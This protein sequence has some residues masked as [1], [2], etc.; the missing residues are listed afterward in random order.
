MRVSIST[1]RRVTGCVLGVV[2]LGLLAS[3]GTSPTVEAVE[4][5][6]DGVVAATIKD[7]TELA[8]TVYNSNIA[9]VRDVRQVALPTGIL[10][11]R[12]LDIAATVNPATVHFR[13]L[14]EPSRLGILEQNYQFDLLDPQ[15]LLK[16]Y[17]GRDVTLVRTRMDNGTS[18]QE[19]VT[20]RLLAFNDA[21]VWKIGD[22]IV[23]GMHV[24]QYRFPEIPENLHSRPTLVWKVDNS[25]QRQHRI[26]TS[27]LATNMSWM[28]D[29]V[30]IVARDDARAD[31]DGWVTV[32]NTSGTSYKNAKLQL[33]A[34]DLHRVVNGQALD[35]R[36]M[37]K[38]AREEAAAP[39][40]FNRE[41]FSEYHLYALNR[42]TT[43]LENET[44]QIALLG[45]TGVPVKKLFVVNGQ[46][47]YYR[48]RQAP[49]SPLKDQVRVF[50]KFRNSEQAGLGMPMPAGTVRVYQADSKG[51]IQFAGEDR[52]DHTPKDEDLTLQI[53]T[54][55]DVVAERKQTD[56]EKVAEGV[57]E[58]AFE[59]TLRNHKATPITVEVN[60]PIAGDWR[61][62]T[63]T[64]QHTKT[65]AWAAQFNVD[66]A[67]NGESVLRYRVRV[68]W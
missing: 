37:A 1:W 66:V 58:M 68:K 44:K 56:W 38:M 26:E 24:E 65:D 14:T 33:V 4:P 2:T 57:Y 10:D 59:I 42:K 12:F 34:G 43:L 21:P 55:F 41:A 5:D 29:Y 25:G 48:N 7:Q 50:Y 3:G 36:M 11:L 63:S 15:R 8:V 13:S 35:D 52:I 16:K 22:E 60:E 28:A 62:L 40:A 54:A 32:N 67:A 64:H 17:I 49:G 53:G 19:E 27:Y 20:A 46:N 30:L 6:D 9:L 31:L 23:T 18:R 39:P 47:F 51:G 61:M 45:G